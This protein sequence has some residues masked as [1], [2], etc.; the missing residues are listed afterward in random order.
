MGETDKASAVRAARASLALALLGALGCG[1][2]GIDGGR[3]DS[4]ADARQTPA[5]PRGK[6][7]LAPEL[8]EV[9][10][11]AEA[12]RF[13]LGKELAQQYVD[14][15][16]DDAQG[17]FV[18][19]LA[20]YW[21]GNYGAARPWL[22]RALELDP[23]NHVVHDSLGYSL[24]MLGELAGARREYEAFVAADPGDPKGHYGLGLIELD[25]SRLDAAA[26]RFRRA[27]E[28][29]EERERAAPGQM[30]ARTPELAECH[31]RLAE[32]HFA[33]AEFEAARDELVLATTICPGNI[34][35]FYTLSLVYRRL[36][37]EELAAQAAQRYESARQALIDGQ[38]ARRE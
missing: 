12:R 27:I 20:H 21:T 17:L 7:P 19:G 30:S 36:G 31:A 5:P 34:S 25:E 11:A 10:R 2:E 9:F 23:E 1:G 24:F 33:R 6:R 22:E 18:L 14:A 15:H 38:K 13:E 8:R 29:F 4:G 37:S 16:P 32:V 3:S 35:A 28:V 26:A